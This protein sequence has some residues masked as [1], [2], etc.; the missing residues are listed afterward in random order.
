MFSVIAMMTAHADNR[1]RARLPFTEKNN[2]AKSSSP[3]MCRQIDTLSSS[4]PIPGGNHQN[5]YPSKG[6]ARQSFSSNAPDNARK[7]VW[8]RETEL[9]WTRD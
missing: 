2:F 9:A 6:M 3:C 5:Q 8:C 7:P 1:R 4:A